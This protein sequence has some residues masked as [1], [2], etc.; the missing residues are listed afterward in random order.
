MSYTTIGSVP[1]LDAA[2]RA[3]AIAE[4]KAKAKAQAEAKARAAKQAAGDA[5]KDAGKD[6][7]GD[8]GKD[9]GKSKIS[10]VVIGGGIAALA[11]IGFLAMKM[12]K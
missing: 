5:G 10:P 7:G 3:K 12:R 8:A 9:A 1:S 4:A 6:A 11:A 2:K